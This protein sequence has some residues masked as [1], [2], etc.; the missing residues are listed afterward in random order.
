MNPYTP[1]Q[2]MKREAAHAAHLARIAEQF[3]PIPDDDLRER[4]KRASHLAMIQDGTLADR[5]R[6]EPEGK[7]CGW[8]GLNPHIAGVGEDEPRCRSCTRNDACTQP[9]KVPGW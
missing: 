7:F 5:M 9:F 1:D 4:C 6:K 3:P 8:A 2:W